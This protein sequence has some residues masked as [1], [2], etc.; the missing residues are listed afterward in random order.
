MRPSVVVV[1]C[2][3]GSL[4]T[5][6]CGSSGASGPVVSV[7]PQT[8]TVT[9]GD[10]ATTFVAILSNGAVAPVSWALL[11]GPGSI[12]TTSGTQTAYQP[13]PLGGSG[14]TASLR[15]TAACGAGCT[16][17]DTA[18]ITVNTATTGTLTITVTGL[19]T[20][21]PASL[22][23]SGPNGYSQAVSTVNATTLTGLAPGAYTVTG[24]DIGDSNNPVVNSKS[25]APPAQA[26]VVANAQASVTVAYAPVPGYGFLWVA[27]GASLEGFTPGNLQVDRAPSITPSTA[28]P[29]QG[30]AF[31]AT[32]A[33]WTSQLGPPDAVVSY[34]AAG[35]A[36]SSPLSPAVTLTQ[37]PIS[38]PV[39]VALGPDGRLWVANCSTNAVAAYPLT[40]G[41]A[42][43]VITTTTGPAPPN[44][45]ACPVGIAFDSSGNLWVANRDG[46]AE[47]FP[48]TQ[49]STTT[50]HPQPDTTLTAPTSPASSQPYGLALDA[51]GNLWVAFCGGSTVALY[52]VSGATVGSVPVTTFSQTGTPLS[53]DCPV[54]LALDN[55]GDLFVANAGTQ[56]AGG[57]L[58]WYSAPAM[59]S[60]GPVQPVLQLTNITVTVGGLAFN[61]TPANLPI[62]H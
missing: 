6:G 29:V 36:N 1:L 31:D 3:L 10:G 23:V 46:V 52:T 16:V 42:Q 57:T 14:G 59:S 12:S 47:R 13:P 30:I 61:P 50:T 45:F 62:F 51:E 25:T 37:S 54:A 49:I 22:T 11:S 15:A 38:D 24:A 35:L 4:W 27:G 5:L 32:G 21:A 26:T 44:A 48:S 53:L 41:A 60:S 18:T 19:P 40:G 39:G 8:L 17:V 7:S 28:G 2:T 33:V 43:V 34:A 56:G 58:S 55:S 20:T 9:T